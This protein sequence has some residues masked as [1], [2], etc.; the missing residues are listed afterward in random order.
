[1]LA[2]RQ[3][4]LKHSFRFSLCVSMANLKNTTPSSIIDISIQVTGPRVYCTWP[5]I[6]HDKGVHAHLQQMA[7]HS[8]CKELPYKIYLG[9]HETFRI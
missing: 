7:P 3:R 9:E 2:I 5:G 8:K 1:M 4:S 6:E